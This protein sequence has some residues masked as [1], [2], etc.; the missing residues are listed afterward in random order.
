MQSCPL[1]LRLIDS[2][3]MIPDLG[4]HSWKVIPGEALGSVAG[5]SD[6]LNHA[7]FTNGLVADPGKDP[8]AFLRSVS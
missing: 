3:V 2:K 6:L 7:I 8:K 1:L 5:C 4:Y